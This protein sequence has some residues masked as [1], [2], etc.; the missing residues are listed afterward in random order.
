MSLGES[1]RRKVAR[2][3]LPLAV[4]LV[5]SRSHQVPRQLALESLVGEM[6]AAPN[7]PR[8]VGVTQPC[9]VVGSGVMTTRF[10]GGVQS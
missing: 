10:Q 5:L 4:V 9:G 3:R 6:R 7:E 2:M 1:A 8:K